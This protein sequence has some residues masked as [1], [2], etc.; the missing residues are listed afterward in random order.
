MIEKSLFLR[1]LPS[2]TLSPD[3]NISLKVHPISDSL[4][5]NIIKRWNQADL[6]YFGSHFDR[7]YRKGEIVL[8]GENIYYRNVILFVQ[9]FESLVTF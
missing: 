3:L 4:P 7:I 1:E 2:S 6:D 9:H 8:V 5:K